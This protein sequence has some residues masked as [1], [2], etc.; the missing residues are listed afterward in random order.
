M[1]RQADAWVSSGV[2][3]PN[4]QKLFDFLQCGNSTI[5][6][7]SVH[8][9]EITEFD[10]LLPS[11][12]KAITGTMK[13]HQLHTDDKLSV[14]YRNLSCFCQRPTLCSCYDLPRH[15][16]PPQEPRSVSSLSTSLSSFVLCVTVC[17]AENCGSKVWLFR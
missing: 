14:S 15:G 6:F 16:F 11:T 9:A 5:Q 2:D 8:P 13:I 4:A 7:H 10:A 12:L 3:V 17:L 1:K